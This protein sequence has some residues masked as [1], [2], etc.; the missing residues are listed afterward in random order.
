ML[1]VKL[2]ERIESRLNG[3]G[4][5]GVGTERVTLFRPVPTDPVGCR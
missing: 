5:A 3:S 2:Y 4:D 1:N